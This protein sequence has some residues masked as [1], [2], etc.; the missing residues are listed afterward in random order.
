MPDSASKK[1]WKDV[2]GAA[3]TGTITVLRN[4]IQEE[5]IILGIRI[6][7]LGGFMLIEQEKP[8]STRWL[9]REPAIM[10]VTEIPLSVMFSE[11]DIETE[12]RRFIAN[13]GGTVVT[14]Y[15]TKCLPIK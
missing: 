3:P 5:G 12:D 14:I 10:S 9:K 8:S 2:A 11:E 7:E 13:H 6:D 4:G 15:V 1:T